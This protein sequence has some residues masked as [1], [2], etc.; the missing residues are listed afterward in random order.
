M[1]FV[2]ENLPDEDF[3]PFVKDITK[4]TFEKTGAVL[5]FKKPMLIDYSQLTQKMFAET[6]D[7]SCGLIS[8]HAVQLMQKTG[9]GN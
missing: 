7:A 6:R 1:T 5:D 2:I 3:L 9:A 4:M 8:V